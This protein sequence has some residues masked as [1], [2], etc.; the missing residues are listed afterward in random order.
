M[1]IRRLKHL[2]AL[3]DERNFGRAAQQC[4]LTQSAFS[5]SIMAAEE[6]FGLLLFDR[7]TVEATCTDAGAFVVEK[8]RKLLFGARCLERD[9]GL[10]RE[11]LIGDLAFGAGPFPAATVVAPLLTEVRSHYP[12]VHVRVEVSNADYLAAHLRAEQLD[13]YLA[14]LR[15]VEDADDLSVRKYARIAAG[16]YVRPGHSLLG[17]RSVKMA[18]LLPYGIAS[19]R[20]PGALQKALGLLVDLDE[21]L[22]LAIE[23][24]DL[25]LLKTLGASTD[26]VV[27]CPDG[28]ANTEFGGTQL[29][30]LTVTDM[31]PLYADMGIVS[32]KGRS[33]SPMA[34]FAVDFISRIQA[35]SAT[36]VSAL[37]SISTGI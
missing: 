22:P 15:I 35:E 2:V 12:G 34:Q 1:D 29:D 16:F 25:T 26:T 32:L 21:G 24:D 23:C 8:A 4:H 30:R 28:L 36:V 10:Y 31:P 17:K 20:I 7:G 18:D 11:R 33:F 3:A 5:R 14:D 27:A 37:Q 19:V 13:F 6:E 9:V